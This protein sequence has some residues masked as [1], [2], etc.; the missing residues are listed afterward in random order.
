MGGA[1]GDLRDAR[2]EEDSRK[3]S[4]GV[5]QHIRADSQVVAVAEKIASMT[6][7]KTFFDE[8]AKRAD[9]E[10]ARKILTRKG[11]EPPRPGDEL[12]EG[13]ERPRR[14]RG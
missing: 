9:L 12:P 3:D 6:T 8:R 7:A 10:L 5:V 13:W 1:I 4:T 2:R 11:G 14:R